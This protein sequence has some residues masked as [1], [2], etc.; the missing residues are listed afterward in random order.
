MIRPGSNRATNNDLS[1]FQYK[2]NI[3]L[4]AL[5]NAKNNSILELYAGAGDLW[6]GLNVNSYKID[7]NP[8][9][10]ADY[11]GD[12][13]SWLKKND[14]YKYGLI[15]VDS[16]GSPARALDIIFTKKYNGVVVC[17]FCS[18]VLLNPCKILGKSYWGE[19]YDKV[20]KKTILAKGCDEMIINYLASKNIN[21]INGF[22][23]H[24]K[25]YF[26]FKI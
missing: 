10:N 7:A 3:R 17:T 21:K 8:I 6:K 20:S 24:K 22:L 4:S 12:C 9:F 19:A 25:C 18:P 1:F 5:K 26:W 2:K 13:I 23:S 14:I 16:W 15:D 11:T